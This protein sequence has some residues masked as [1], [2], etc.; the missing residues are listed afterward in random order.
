L[1][2]TALA[3]RFVNYA[4]AASVFPLVQAVAFSLTLSETD[5]R[6]SVAEIWELVILGNMFFAVI[7]TVAVVVFRRAELALRIDTTLDTLVS[8]YLKRL[9]IGRY[10]LIWL[11]YGYTVFNAFSATLDPVCSQ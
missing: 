2:R 8:K 11:S 7:V 5:I 9:Q 4:D 3:D 10:V 6:C 1:E